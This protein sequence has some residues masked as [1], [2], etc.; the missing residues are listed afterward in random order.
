MNINADTIVY[1]PSK[2]AL[3]LGEAI[4]IIKD[5]I[6]AEPQEHYDI[7]I[8]TDS[9]TRGSTTFCLAIVIHR[10]HKGGIFFYKRGVHTRINNLRQKLE[11]ETQISIEVAD[12]FTN[13]IPLGN[14]DVTLQIHMDIGTG[15]PTRDL[16]QELEGWISAL[17][18]EYEIKPDSYAASSIADRYSK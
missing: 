4:D 9:M 12:Y 16:I 2:G 10:V 1:S 3:T 18:Y 8:G 15:G 7:S 17:G 5:Y 14:L 13:E 11:Q 6:N